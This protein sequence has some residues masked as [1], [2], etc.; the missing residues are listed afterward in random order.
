[1]IRRGGLVYK[2]RTSL[3]ACPGTSFSVFS[4]DS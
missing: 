4:D 2:K 3:I 1:L